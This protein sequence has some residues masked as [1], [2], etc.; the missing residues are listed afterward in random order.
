MARNALV[1]AARLTTIES[2][3]RQRRWGSEYLPSMKASRD[4]A[5][6]ISRPSTLYSTKLERTIHLMSLPERAA[7]VLAL[8]H[9]ALFD[10]HEQHMLFPFPATHPLEGHPKAAGLNLPDVLGT[11]DV[12]QRL[13]MLSKHPTVNIEMRDT[14]GETTVRRAAFPYIGD[15]LLFLED[16]E[17]PY[18][19]NWTV[20]R[21]RSSFSN[22]PP[23]PLSHLKKDRNANERRHTLEE[24]YFADAS[25]RTVR[26]AATDIDTQLVANL[27]TLAAY[28]ARTLSVPDK[29]IS[30]LVEQFQKLVGLQQPVISILPNLVERTGL[31]RSTCLA[32]FYRAVWSRLVRV[33]LY[34]PIL[35]DKPLR[36]E[37]TDVLEDFRQWFERGN[38]CK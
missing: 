20:K 12:A 24:Q 6:T 25:I 16:S 10:L 11:I 33:D 8:Y 3:Q 17:G 28:D 37:R 9:P 22:G 31:D 35:P 19:I 1:S 26:V 30:I 7:C 29:L 27:T 21:D 14:P 36:P 5:P 4:E 23:G 34:R 38:L 2:R 18:C 13:N 15:L 32:I